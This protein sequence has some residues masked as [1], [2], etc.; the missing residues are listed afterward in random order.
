MSSEEI[1]KD[2]NA[3]TEDFVPSKSRKY[4]KN[5][6]KC[7]RNGV[8]KQKQQKPQRKCVKLSRR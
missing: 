4:F 1:E 5:K 6:L 7:I 2:A 3:V 8:S